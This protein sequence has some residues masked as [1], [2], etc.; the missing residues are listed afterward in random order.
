MH[1]QSSGGEGACFDQVVL[2]G[3]GRW[4]SGHAA[5]DGAGKRLS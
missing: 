4:W 2:E 1:K 5:L 3:P